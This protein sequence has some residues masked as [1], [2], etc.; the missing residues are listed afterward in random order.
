MKN[1]ETA[2]IAC[3]TSTAFKSEL[4][5]YARQKDLTISQIIRRAVTTLMRQEPI[6]SSWSVIQR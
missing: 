6:R 1:T 5:N 4:D 3:R 2:L